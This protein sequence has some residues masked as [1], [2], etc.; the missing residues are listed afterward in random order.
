MNSEHL[1]DT[2]K[3]VERMYKEIFRGYT[4]EPPKVTVFNNDVSKNQ[5]VV[6]QG[7][8]RSFCSHHMAIFSGKYYFGYIPNQKLVGLSKIA[9]IID[10]FSS[11]LQSQETLSRDVL[12]YFEKHVKPLGC[13]LILEAKHTCK[14]SRGAKKDG[15]MK[16]SEQRGVFLHPKKGMTPKQEFFELIKRRD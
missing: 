10:H 12:D 9:R 2:P 7:D 8:F 5:I 3:R 13:C 6:D 4:E 14:S 16:T 1:V 15:V 11:K